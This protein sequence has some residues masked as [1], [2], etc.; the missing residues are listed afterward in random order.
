M[1][2]YMEILVMNTVWKI[3]EILSCGFLLRLLPMVECNGRC[4]FDADRGKAQGHTVIHTL[5]VRYTLH[6][7]TEYSQTAIFHE[8]EIQMEQVETSPHE[9]QDSLCKATLQSRRLSF[10]KCSPRYT[11]PAAKPEAQAHWKL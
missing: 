7:S 3:L 8:P 4:R 5:H 10:A 1:R 9:V 11:A 6:L 2:L